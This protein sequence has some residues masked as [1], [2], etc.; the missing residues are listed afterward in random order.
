MCGAIAD[1]ST[2]RAFVS[3]TLAE[4]GAT[5]TIQDR[6]AL[7]IDELCTNSLVHGYGTEPGYLRIEVARIGS[8]YYILFADRAGGFD[9]TSVTPVPISGDVGD[10]AVGGLG[11]LLVR[12]STRQ[13]RYLRVDN[14]NQTTAIL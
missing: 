3:Q 5:D 14:E 4:L 10:R 11:L 9:P 1:V 6:G 2:I 8:S 7:V 12:A 13:L